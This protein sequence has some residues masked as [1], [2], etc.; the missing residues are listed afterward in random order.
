MNNLES[1][2]ITLFKKLCE[3]LESMHWSIELINESEK[4]S[5]LGV[6]Y[7]KLL[8]PHGQTQLV[9]EFDHATPNGGIVQNHPL[10]Q[11]APFQ[12]L[13]HWPCIV[14]HAIDV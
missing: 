5:N 12:M 4:Q 14:G 9:Q 8:F 6:N 7:H 10:L 1:K 11:N 13:Y 2:K 3:L